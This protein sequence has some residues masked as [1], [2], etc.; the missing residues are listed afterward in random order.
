M[1]NVPPD[2][3]G[4]RIFIVEDQATLALNLQIALEEAG[5]EIVIVRGPHDALDHLA[6]RI[7]TAPTA[8][9]RAPCKH[10]MN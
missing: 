10:L 8:W 4:L 5:A 7:S 1:K 2:L 9:S 3:S 6:L